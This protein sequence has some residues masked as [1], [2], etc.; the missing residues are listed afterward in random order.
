MRIGVPLCLLLLVC[1][2]AVVCTKKQVHQP[3]RIPASVRTARSTT[4][5]GSDSGRSGT[6][7]VA[8]KVFDAK[9]EQTLAGVA[10]QFWGTD[11]QVVTDE[12]GEF[13]MGN[14]NP[15]KFRLFVVYLGYA[16]EL[17]TGTVAASCTLHLRIGLRTQVLNFRGH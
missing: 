17:V 10:V 9:T 1:L 6:G 13:L 3:P 4:A 7:T 2:C 12:H 16:D 15:G 5:T 8:G 11:S 14:V